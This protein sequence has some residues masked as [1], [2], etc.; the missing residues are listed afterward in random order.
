MEQV[1]STGK[2]SALVYWAGELSVSP[3]DA[4][5]LTRRDTKKGNKWRREVEEFWDLD[6]DARSGKIFFLPK[7]NLVVNS[8]LQTSLDRL[9]N[10]GGPPGA[11]VRMGVD[12][13]VS[14]PVAG[15]T[16]SGANTKTLLAFDSTP[17][18]ASQ[19]VTSIRTFTNSNVN[20]IMKRLFLSRHTA[21]I[22]NSTSAD[23]AGTLYSMTNVFT[24]DF[25]GISSWS[26][27]FS[28]TVTA[29]GS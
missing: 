24:I 28:A 25:T 13:G 6:I 21:D 10:I 17:T 3:E 16:Q 29:T 5:A 18:R 22:T 2:D 23:T 4:R 8:G 12:N 7:K 26:L 19:T 11:L 1:Y 27:V 15:D 20:F 9:L 14:N